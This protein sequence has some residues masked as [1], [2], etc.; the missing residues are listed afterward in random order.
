LWAI[1]LGFTPRTRIQAIQNELSFLTMLACCVCDILMC[2]QRDAALPKQVVLE[3]RSNHPVFR[4]R[5]GGVVLQ[6]FKID[7]IGF[8]C[9][10]DSVWA[11]ISS[12]ILQSTFMSLL[13]FHVKATCQVCSVDCCLFFLPSFPNSSRKYT[14]ARGV[15]AQKYWD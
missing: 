12:F 2:M 11:Q 14:S 6:G 8:R 9:L 7:V 5:H 3:H 10:F 4:I 15:T 13:F 1:P